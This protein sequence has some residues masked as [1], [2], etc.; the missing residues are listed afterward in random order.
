MIPT[1]QSYPQPQHSPYQCT[2][3]ILYNTGNGNPKIYIDAQKNQPK[4][5]DSKE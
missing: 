1:S 5:I 2:N 4:Q 3:D